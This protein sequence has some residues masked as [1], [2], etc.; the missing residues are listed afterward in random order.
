MN[1]H[2]Y[3]QGP[4]D[5]VLNPI[6][7]EFFSSEAVGDSAAAL[8]RESIQNSMDARPS[9][10]AGS[11]SPV[12]VRIL[13]SG[14]AKAVPT[15]DAKRWFEGI[16]PHVEAPRNG[17]AEV[18]RRGDRCPYILIE[19]FGTV[20][21]GGDPS[22]YVIDPSSP[23]D[24][25]NF[26]RAF[27]YSDKGGHSKGSWGVGKT[28]FPRTSRISS[29]FGFTVRSCDSKQML[30]GRAILKY[31][32]CGGVNFKSDGY[33][34]RVREDGFV[35]PSRDL[36]EI[37]AFRE[38]FH[39]SRE[40]QPGLSVV[41]PWYVPTGEGAVQHEDVVQ[42]VAEGFFLPILAGELEVEVEEGSLF[43]KLNAA[44]LGCTVGEYSKPWA[45][46]MRSIVAM[47]TW[48]MGQKGQCAVELN[49]PDATKAQKW[50]S[51]M[52][53]PTNLEK[54][55]ALASQ[56]GPFAVRVPLNI[57]RKQ[58]SPSQTSFVVISEPTED[59]GA[60]VL[61]LRDGLIITDVRP[62][63]VTRGVRAMVVV[64]DEVLAGFLRDAET[65]A[66]TEWHT[67]TANFK[68]KY[69]YGPAAIEFVRAAVPEIYSVLRKSDTT[70]DPALTID[71]F[72]IDRAGGNRT[73]KPSPKKKVVVRPKPKPPRFEISRHEGGFVLRSPPPV[74]TD[75]VPF[76]PF[77]IR[78]R[79]A[80][81]TRKDNPLSTWSPYDF[82]FAKAPLT[83]AAVGISVDHQAGNDLII[84]VEEKEFQLAVSGFDTT[85]DLFVDGRTMRGGT[86]DH[87]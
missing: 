53:T 71:H 39:L 12:R 48:W 2:F 37:D 47:A 35:L 51:G 69:V 49:E 13:L 24:F 64:E 29:F 31:H 16:W 70:A 25:L 41:V 26:F 72:F 30:L 50:S 4:T 52:I 18:P 80:Y 21:L 81:D 54:L 11:A 34:G 43:T 82:D 55:L 8:V 27:G 65:P 67:G 66:H 59:D 83:M 46:R 74:A 58:E 44:S 61:F 23:N 42:A 5:P 86:D 14:S 19:D 60:G 22:A 3:R 73:S 45:A 7:G 15:A 79:A 32:N 20:G 68:S 87:P 10:G 36:D 28:V 78:L 6:A 9:N 84:S 62:T 38:T 56:S 57:R 76:S 17:L 75:P 63:R 1:W 77:R 40:N 85:R 33:Y